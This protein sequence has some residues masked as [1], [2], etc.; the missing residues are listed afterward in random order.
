[1]S[2]SI[3]EEVLQ[4]HAELPRTASGYPSCQVCHRKV[5]RPVAA[6]DGFNWAFGHS[7][8]VPRG[9]FMAGEDFNRIESVL[10]WAYHLSEKRTLGRASWLDVVNYVRPLWRPAAKEVMHRVFLN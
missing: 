8:C 6:S 10:D 7:R 5:A 3:V 1:M 2:V 4:S 9:Y